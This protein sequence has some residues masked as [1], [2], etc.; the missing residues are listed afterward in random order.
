MRKNYS[1]IHLIVAALL[2]ALLL[3][4]STLA[5]TVF[6]STE[7]STTIAGNNEDWFDKDT[8]IWFLPA[9]KQSYGCVYYGFENAHPQGGMNEKGLF[10]DWFARGGEL[11]PLD[12]NK[13]IYPG[14]L[15]DVILRQC[16]TVEEALA[17]YDKYN[18]VNLGYATIL[19][20]DSAGDTA[21]I[22][23]DWDKGKASVER[24]KGGQLS[25][26]V[27][28]NAI[29]PMLEQ[30]D[31]SDEAGF[32]IMLQM[33]SNENTL[34]STLCNLKTKQITLYNQHNY[35]E[36]VVFDLSDELKKGPHVLSIPALFP[37]QKAG[38]A[39]QMTPSSLRTPAQNVIIIALFA[40]LAA[41]AA[42]CLLELI[43]QKKKSLKALSAVAAA[44]NI[45]LLAL[46]LF[47]NERVY[48]IVK[49]GMGLYGWGAVFMSWAAVALTAAQGAFVVRAWVKKE[50]AKGLLIVLSISTAFMLALLLGFTTLGMYA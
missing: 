15:S 36:N 42:C 22:T 45:V 39:N 25:I 4:W 50:Q 9:E 21:A 8:F 32:T 23:W 19:L 26:G 27:G 30:K 44:A 12:D 31:W 5:C 47:I 34:Y 48:F 17:L 14:Q 18:D 10:F 38:E 37:N 41:T 16:S 24:N 13:L 29:R 1:I 2:V 11:A 43:L 28:A 49:Y 46:A 33:A 3:P 40:I 35:Q 20:A 6:A 7:D